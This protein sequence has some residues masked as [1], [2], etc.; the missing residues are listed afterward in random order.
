MS[1]TTQHTITR[2]ELAEMLRRANAYPG[3]LAALEKIAILDG[4]GISKTWEG[5]AV[6]MSRIAAEAISAAKSWPDE[7]DGGD[8]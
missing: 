3:L 2:Q 1:A 5:V 4:E 8:K 6:R 7:L